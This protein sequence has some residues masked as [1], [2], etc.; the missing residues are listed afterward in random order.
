MTQSVLT[1]TAGLA[2][3][4]LESYDV[5]PLPLFRKVHINPALMNDMSSRT[6]WSTQNALWVSVADS[7]GDPCFGLK[8]GGLW[9][10][11]YMHALGYAWLS[12]STLYSALERLSRF[13]NIVNPNISVDIFSDSNI[14]TVEVSNA[15]DTIPRDAPWYADADMSILIAMCRAN[16][17]DSLNPVSLEFRHAQPH[18]TGDFFALFRCPV[19]FGAQH[20]RMTFS[21]KDV[22]K[23]LPGSNT[24]MSQV[25]DQEMVRYLAGLGGGDIIH[26]VK[27]AILELLPD[28]RMSDAKVA[29]ALFMSNRNLQRK[30][31]A[32]GTTFKTI[33]T[34]L[35]KELASKYIQDPQLTLTEISFMLGFSEMSA[36]SRA[37]K[38][39]TGHSP[40]TQR[41]SSQYA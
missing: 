10:P 13:I 17:G 19:S 39:W 8:L 34:E 2:W 5:D 20:N 27:N 18:C 24:L 1:K 22:D 6:N 9:H 35:R 23:Q 28:G 7:V 41:Q 11:S 26:K 32:Q 40:K 38:Q 14:V 36:F 25:H 33:L 4:L 15:S 21:R 30:L 31:E 29:E 37:F 3:S 12:S 16:S